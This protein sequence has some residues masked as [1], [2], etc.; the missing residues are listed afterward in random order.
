MADEQPT[1]PSQESIEEARQRANAVTAARRA[2][3]LK[4]TRGVSY[5]ES[6]WRDLSPEAQDAFNKLRI[7]RGEAPLSPAKKKSDPYI[8]P[9]E[10]LRPLDPN[11]LETVIAARNFLG[12]DE[13]PGKDWKGTGESALKLAQYEVPEGSEAYTK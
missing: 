13:D 7:A 11:D 3:R 8:A 6:R 10:Q 12:L 4:A 1:R 9:P 5:E 2:E